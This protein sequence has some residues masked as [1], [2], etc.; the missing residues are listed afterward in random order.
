[1]KP[2]AANR[3][4]QTAAVRLIKKP[5][6]PEN[7]YRLFEKYVSDE[8]CGDD[9]GEVCQQA[10]SR[11]VA[12]LFYPHAAEIYRDNVERGICRPLNS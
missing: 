11:G 9:S 4:R 3:S 10:V 2:E 5:S 6:L 1:M 8:D 12:R 7:T